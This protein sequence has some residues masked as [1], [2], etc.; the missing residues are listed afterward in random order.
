PT[1]LALSSYFKGN[2]FLERAKAEGC[3]VFLL[4][5]ES[6]RHEPWAREALDDLFLVRTFADRRELI[7]TVAYLFRS[8][9]FD[10]I[11][12]LDDYDVE[13][14]A[15]LREHFRIDGLGDSDARFFRDKLAM[16]MRAKALGVRAP[17][18]C[19][20]F[21][22]VDV[23]H[24]LETVPAPWLLKPRAEAS[25]VG[26]RKLH[27]KDEAWAHIHALGDA[28][29]DHLIERMIAG[30]MYHVDSLVSRGQVVFAVVSRYHKPLLEVA[31]GGGIYA[32]RMLP[33]DAK[34]RA[35]LTAINAKLL[36]G[37]GMRLGASHT[38]F[39][40]GR[41]DGKAYFIET[42]AR[43]G[44]ANIAEMVEG[45]TGLNLW[46]EWAK[47]EIEGPDFAYEVPAAK[48]SYGGVIIS[49]A[50]QE[51][52]DTSSFTDPEIWYRLDK[53]HHIGLVVR[54]P[55]A[56]RVEEL[57]TSYMQRIAVEF[58]AALPPAD[59]ATS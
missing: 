42:S 16:R 28:R 38:E 22:D 1:L 19:P 12:A 24:F 7:H 30:E 11:V 26:I 35:T 8:I 41:D 27:T 45:A 50:R 20:L 15:A 32:T 40:I 14:A 51:V 29:S 4:T 18:F 47:L 5:T 59:R 56:N 36:P 3:R 39:I 23:T 54:S 58:H 10:R 44:G 46:S 2:R 9:R 52:P 25:A 37:F 34:E 21:H 57:L 13:V 53:K 33:R 48:D 49:L 43:V 6:T 17:D 31:Q 55:D